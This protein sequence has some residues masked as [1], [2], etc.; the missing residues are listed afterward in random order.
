M[1]YKTPATNFSI[2]GVDKF[3]GNIGSVDSAGKQE[4]EINPDSFTPT[5]KVILLNY[6]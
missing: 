4:I 3:L 1:H 6:E 5:A 2:D